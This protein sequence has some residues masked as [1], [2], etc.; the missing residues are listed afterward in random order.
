MKEEPE[1]LKEG[2]STFRKG[3]GGAMCGGII[4][5]TQMFSDVERFMMAYYMEDE[6][7]EEYKK[8]KEEGKNKEATKLFEKY[9]RSII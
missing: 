4:S 2:E 8:L 6:K 5:K 7:F 1:I 9:G 3:G